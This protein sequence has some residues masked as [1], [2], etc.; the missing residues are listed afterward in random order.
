MTLAQKENREAQAA[1]CCKFTEDVINHEVVESFRTA[2]ASE[3][4]KLAEAGDGAA[5]LAVGEFLCAYGST[6]RLD[7]LSKAARQG[8]SDAW[9][10]LGKEYEAAI[11]IDQNRQPRKIPLTNE[12]ARKFRGKAAEC[13]LQGAEANNGVMAAWCQCKIGD[14]YKNGNS[15]LPK[16]VDLAIYWYQVAVESGENR[17]RGELESLQESL[18]HSDD[19]KRRQAIANTYNESNVV[20][21]CMQFFAVMLSLRKEAKGEHDAFPG[22][23]C[24]YTGSQDG[25]LLSMDAR[26]PQWEWYLTDSTDSNRVQGFVFI[27]E[28]A[29][30]NAQ[31]DEPRLRAVKSFFDLGIGYALNPNIGNEWISFEKRIYID[32]PKEKNI[33]IAELKRALNQK[34]TYTYAQQ[35]FRIGHS[36]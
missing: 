22:V 27:L 30:K 13:F 11:R 10:Y 14:Y 20:Q 6:E 2:Y 23:I 7:W 9:Y 15:I 18:L 21:D 28:S 5:Q 12:Q 16:D 26:V 3:L 34:Y 35:E 1:L 19:G 29:L 4:W 17:A 33:Y 25:F 8:L 36:E 24:C 32:S 31:K